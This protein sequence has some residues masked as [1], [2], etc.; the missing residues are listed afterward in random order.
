MR[1]VRI[2]LADDQPMIYGAV[3]SLLKPTYEIVACV[4]DG[5]ALIRA[6]MRMKPE[7][8]VTDI[9]MPVLNGIEAA[10]K[11]RDSGSTS[12][13]IFLTIHQDLDYIK[14]CFAAG[15]LAYVSKPRMS[16]DLLSAIQEALVG[17]RFVSPMASKAASF[18]GP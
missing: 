11:L 18:P 15:A 12:R 2:L 6:A 7:V 1:K 13:I 17:H 10:N 16:T 8:I 3:A 5:R 14:A 4:G 9:S